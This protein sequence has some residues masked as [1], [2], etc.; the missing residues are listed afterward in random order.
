MRFFLIIMTLF[1]YSW[2]FAGEAHEE[3]TPLIGPEKGIL[4]KSDHGF[5]LAPEALQTL[6]IQ[7]AAAPTKVLKVPSAALVEIKNGRF[8]YL[9][10][11]G[12]FTRVPVK[13]RKKDKRSVTIEIPQHQS[14]D[15]YVSEGVGFVRTTEILIEEGASHGHSH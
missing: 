8:L 12:W 7:T 14:G 15:A 6:K 10:R 4:A 11:E 2:A 13:V 1:F 9:V 5:K 3:D